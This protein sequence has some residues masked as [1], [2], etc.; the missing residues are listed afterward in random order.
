MPPMLQTELERVKNEQ[1][2]ALLTQ[3]KSGIIDAGLIEMNALHD[4]YDI[5]RKDS[6]MR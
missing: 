5:P 4:L 1:V 3:F 2:D 6:Y